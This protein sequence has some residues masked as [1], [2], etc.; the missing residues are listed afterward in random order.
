MGG[1]QS[2]QVA[3]AYH[4]SVFVKVRSERISVSY[5]LLQTN[6]CDIP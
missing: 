5:V 4:D 1:E 3:N 2:V 6:Q